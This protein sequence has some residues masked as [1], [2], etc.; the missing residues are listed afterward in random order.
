[1]AV[2]SCL[3][4]GIID[5]QIINTIADI[6][7][8]GVLVCITW[9]YAHQIEKRAGTD[10]LQKEMDLL[11]SPLY[12]KSQGPLKAVYFIKGSSGNI[13]SVRPRDREYFDFWDNVLRN[14]YLGPEYL[15]SALENYY[16]KNKTNDVMDRKRD[17][18][19]EKAEGELIEKISTRYNELQKEI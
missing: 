5:W 3:P 12:A 1:M 18:E 17:S 14:K 2:E 4:C 8:T 16:F 19:Y 10:R 6:L 15:Q 7:L 11:I 9:W 13:D